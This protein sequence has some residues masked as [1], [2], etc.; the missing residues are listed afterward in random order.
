MKSVKLMPGKCCNQRRDSIHPVSS[1]NILITVSIHASSAWLWLQDECT[2]SGI[3]TWKHAPVCSEIIYVLMKLL[4]DMK[5]HWVRQVHHWLYIKKKSSQRN[6][7]KLISKATFFQRF[8]V[9]LV[10][11]GQVKTH[12]CNPDCT[13]KYQPEESLWGKVKGKWK[14]KNAN[15]QTSWYFYSCLT[16]AGYDNKLY[17]EEKASSCSTCWWVRWWGLFT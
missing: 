2:H 5:A 17:L 9:E 13:T 6:Q 7:S 12:L 15:T 14:H 16:R 11:E 4:V 1:A 8:F 10:L 3:K